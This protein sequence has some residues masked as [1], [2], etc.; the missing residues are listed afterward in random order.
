[1]SPIQP[2]FRRSRSP[3]VLL[4][5]MKLILPASQPIPDH[6]RPHIRQHDQLDRC[7]R[8]LPAVLPTPV[9]YTLDHRFVSLTPSSLVRPALLAQPASL[10]ISLAA[11][12]RF[13]P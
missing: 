12:K 2:E 3:R 8:K 11:Q 7:I 10:R 9:P 5:F 4:H 13:P 1:M 6:P